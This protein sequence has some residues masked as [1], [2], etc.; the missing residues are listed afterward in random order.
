MSIVFFDG[1]GSEAIEAA[2]KIA[3]Q[4]FIEKEGLK[5]K[6]VNIIAREGSYHGSTMAAMSVSFIKS[7]K[8]I[9]SPFLMK[10][11]HHVF[12]CNP[13]RQKLEGQFDAEFVA[14]KADELDKMFIKLGPETVIG[15]IAEPIVG[16]AQGC[17]AY[18]PGYFE[19]MKKVCEDHKALLILDEIMCGMGRT[20]TMHAWQGTGIVPDIQT[21]AKALGGGFIPISAM[22][23]SPKINKVLY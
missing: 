4:Y 19:A 20:E 13:Y 15:F 12:S 17:V 16:A 3:R 8:E 21:M 2:I 14:N 9:Y 7:R 22:M 6:R 23:I 5:T 18:V 10:N 1:S 11:V